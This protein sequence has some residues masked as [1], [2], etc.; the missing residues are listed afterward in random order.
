MITDKNGHPVACITITTALRDE[1][2]STIQM[3]II[4]NLEAIKEFLKIQG[5]EDVCAGLYTYAIEEYGKILFLKSFS[6]SAANEITFPYRRDG[7]KGFLNH[8][9][10]FPRALDDKQLPDSCKTLREGDFNA[11][12]YEPDDYITEITADFDARMALFY[13]DF[14]D[15]DSILEPPPVDRPLLQNAVDDFLTFMRKQI[16]L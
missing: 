13:A 1:M 4:H 16:F 7:A 10:K 12:D 15:Q 3:R 2:M 8:H 5:Y 14:K 6:V 9:E 11:D